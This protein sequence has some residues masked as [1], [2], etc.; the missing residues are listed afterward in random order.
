MYDICLPSYLWFFERVNNL[1]TKLRDACLERPTLAHLLKEAR[2]LATLAGDSCV[3]LT[4]DRPLDEVWRWDAR[5]LS[6]KLECPVVGRLRHFRSSEKV[7]VDRDVVL[8]RL[9]VNGRCLS[10]WQQAS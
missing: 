1:M 7:C 10:Y 9:S 2:F 4:Y 5:W 8:E 6:E 3:T